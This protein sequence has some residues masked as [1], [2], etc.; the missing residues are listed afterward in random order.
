MISSDLSHFLPYA[1]AQQV[2]G[3]TCRH[4]LKLSNDIDPHQACGAFPRNNFV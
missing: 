1:T 3:E 2:D 4:I